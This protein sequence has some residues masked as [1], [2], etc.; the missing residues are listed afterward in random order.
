[1][2]SIVALLAGFMIV[3]RLIYKQFFSVGRRLDSSDWTILMAMLLSL[4]TIAI[5]IF[6]M[7]LHGMGKDLWG[8]SPN[9]LIV[10]GLCFY[11]IQILYVILMGFIKIS[12][13]LFYLPLFP[14]NTIRNLLWGTIGFHVLFTVGFTVGIIF[15]CVPISYQRAKYDLANPHS[16]HAR[17]LDINASGWANAALTL[18]SDIWLIGIPLSQLHKLKLHW[19][20][21]AGAA[22]MFLTGTAVTIVSVLRL[23]SIKYYANTTNPTWDQYDLSSEPLIERKRKLRSADS[24]GCSR[25]IINTGSI[26]DP[27]TLR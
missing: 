16:A 7:A 18:A 20:K 2:I 9:D 3:V 10:F 1:M 25:V 15:Q 26:G 12:L 11:V 6:G 19:K 5:T 22:F 24:N 13:T 27:P 14:G 8:I 23:R 21:K 4:P 17:C